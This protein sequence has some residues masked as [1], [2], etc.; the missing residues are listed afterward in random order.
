MRRFLRLAVFSSLFSLA[1]APAFGWSTKEHVQLTRIAAERLIAD[2][3]T[4]PEMK[5]W[6]REAAPDL[7]DMEGEKNW[8]MNQ[9][10]GIVPRGVDGLAYWSVI[11]DENAL[12]DGEK[13]TP[14]FNVPERQLHFIDLEIFVTGDAKR[15]YRNDLSA[16]PRIENIPRDM[17]DPRYMQAGMLPFR[18]ADCYRKLVEQIR[19]GRLI[20]RDGQYPRDEHA[21]H[22]AGFLAHY[23]EDNTQPQHATIDYKSSAYFAD[24]RKAPN[25]HAQVEYQLADDDENDHLQTREDFWPLFVAA[26]DTVN[27]PTKTDDLFEATLQISLASYDALPLIGAAAMKATGQAGTPDHPAGEISGKF[28]TDVFYHAKGQYLGREMSVMEMKAY[29]QA[30]AVKRV[31]RVLRQAWDEAHSP[32]TNPSAK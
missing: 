31:E 9:R 4:P 24:K 23:L 17:K 20:D 25:V 28:D 21:T 2:D 8:F 27:D 14:P 29:Q 22:W 10:M 7:M 30:W 5:A 18:V 26:L 11:P 1:A 3:K 16:K 32:A 15:E 19:A 13:K 6:L 12:M